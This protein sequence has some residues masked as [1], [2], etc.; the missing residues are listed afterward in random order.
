MYEKMLIVI[1]YAWYGGPQQV[2]IG[3]GATLTHVGQK[4]CTVH[5]DKDPKDIADYIFKNRFESRP[6]TTSEIKEIAIT[7]I[8]NDSLVLDE[9]RLKFLKEIE[10]H[11]IQKIAVLIAEKTEQEA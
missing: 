4:T 5:E 2:A 6:Q 11:L 10:S 1:A 9:K 8:N 3:G 7:G